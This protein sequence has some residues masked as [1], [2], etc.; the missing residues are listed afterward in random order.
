[1]GRSAPWIDRV[2]RVGGIAAAL[3]ALALA[4]VALARAGEPDLTGLWWRVHGRGAVFLATT[5]V[6]GAIACAVSPPFLRGTP[7]SRAGS[8]A[9]RRLYWSVM[10]AFW[11]V[12]IAVPLADNLGLAWILLEAS[13]AASALLIAFSG[14]ASAVEAGWKYL[15]LTSLGLAFT[16][17][18]IV[19]LCVQ[20]AAG[21]DGAADLGWDRIAAAAPGLSGAAIVA[22]YV[23]ML[24]GLATKGGWA[25]VHNWLPD[26]HSE[27]PPPVSA[28]LSA[29]LLPTVVLV[30]WRLGAALSPAV[31][32][33]T[34]RGLFVAFGLAS[35]AVA[36]P[37]L[38]KP[39]PWKRL[40]AYSSLEHMGVLVLAIGIDNRVATAGALIHVAGHGVAK[41][42]GFAAAV[43]LLRYQPAAGRRPARGLGQLSRPPRGGGQR[44]P[45]PRSRA[46][47]PPRCS[48]PR[49]S[50]SGA[51]RRRA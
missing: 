40:L 38:W 37:F 11:A 19:M 18:G 45:R 1:M 44:E 25:P 20:M 32:A 24:A 34:V 5:A 12:L 48:S 17:F 41:A 28:L 7:T 13:T 2:G 9:S 21:P 30:A 39:L 27:A 8:L 42:L 16:L 33:D 4:G 35:L 14:K 22:A 51:P 15:V 31:G 29:A 46:C 6:V 23:L 47:R 10:L 36:V 50:S 26:A 49:S 43:P 3:P